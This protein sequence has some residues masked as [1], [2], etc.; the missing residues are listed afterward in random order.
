MLEALLSWDERMFRL[1]NE[2]WL[3]P[4]LD[5]A[6]PF[7]S[8]ARNY[9]IP[10]MLA[11]I[12]ILYVGRLRGLRFLA[13]AIVSVVVADAISTHVFKQAFLRTRPCIAL[14]GV[15]QLAGC[16]NSPSL[17]SN[18]AVNAAALAAL[19]ALHMPRL[20]L[21]A[22]ALALLVSYSRI[23]V[24]THYP[25]DVLAGALLGIAVALVFSKA[26]TLLWPSDPGPVP[27]ERRRL[28]SLSFGDR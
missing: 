19:V 1:L 6:M 3:H 10:F 4:V 22:V 12:V 2:V 16:V 13:L 18:H 24:G 15:R 20:W 5:R 9:G 27:E 14:E 8:D 25:L 7:I 11:A 17:P 21:P 23:Y 26:M 28:F